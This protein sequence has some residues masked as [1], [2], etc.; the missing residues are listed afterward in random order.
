LTVIL[1]R[2]REAAGLISSWRANVTSWRDRCSLMYRFT[3]STRETLKARL[4]RERTQRSKEYRIQADTKE[5]LR[6]H[7]I[8]P[9]HLPELS[10]HGRRRILQARLHVQ[11][12]LIRRWIVRRAAHHHHWHVW[13]W[14]RNPVVRTARVL[15]VAVQVLV[16][17]LISWGIGFECGDINGLGFRINS[18]GRS[19]GLFR[20]H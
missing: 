5:H 9:G 19:S 10:Q 13:L 3:D 18:D 2:R 6:R 12:Q 11:T 7:T 1:R 15:S 20:F 14:Q 16:R 17:V 8:A 4:K